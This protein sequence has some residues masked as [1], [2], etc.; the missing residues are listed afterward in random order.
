[1]QAPGPTAALPS[2]AMANAHPCMLARGH[3][4]GRLLPPIAGELDPKDRAAQGEMLFEPGADE[5]LDELLISSLEP[6]GDHA[7]DPRGRRRRRRARVMR[8]A[9]AAVVVACVL[10]G[11]GGSHASTV[12]S[13]IDVGRTETLDLAETDPSFLLELP[14]PRGSTAERGGAG[15]VDVHVSRDYDL[16]VTRLEGTTVEGALAA[17]K[18]L[19]ASGLFRNVKVLSAD[20]ESFVY[21]WQLHTAPEPMVSFY[22]VIEGRHGELYRI[23]DGPSTAALTAGRAGAQFSAP[24]ARA[25]DDLAARAKPHQ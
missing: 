11:C 7:G 6:G 13:G 5:I 19:I 20:A 14:V 15:A 25:V 17:S 24:L 4:F 23:G 2:E 10:A 3:R 22:R 1:M 18:R 9:A 16:T 8:R 12:L 21:R